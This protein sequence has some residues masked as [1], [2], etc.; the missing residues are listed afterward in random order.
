MEDHALAPLSTSLCLINA[1]F[2]ADRQFGDDVLGKLFEDVV[3]DKFSRIFTGKNI[4]VQV[5]NHRPKIPI[6]VLHD[7]HALLLL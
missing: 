5:V 3:E 7:G 1:F 2:D 4:H 6:S